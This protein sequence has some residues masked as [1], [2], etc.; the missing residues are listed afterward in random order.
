MLCETNSTVLPLAP[1]VSMRP[2]QRAWNSASPTASTSSTRSISGSKCAATENA[3]RTYIPL[4]YRF[5]G[6]SMKDSTPENS[7]ISGKLRLDLSALHPEDRAVQVDVLAAGELGVESCADLEQASD[8]TTDLDAARRGVRDPGEHLQQRRLAGAVGA[9]HAEHL[10]FDDVER[11]VLQRPDLL[12]L[13]AMLLAREQPSGMDE[14]LSKRSVGSLELPEPVALGEPFDF[15][16][17]GHQIVSAKRGSDDRNT[18]RPPTK[19]SAPTANP[20]AVCPRSG[21]LRIEHCPAPASDHGSHRVERE[22]PLPLRRGSPRP[23]T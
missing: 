4:E 13:T 15:D 8:A 5:T 6:V 7:A 14:R 11:D 16:R 12:H 9:D 1:N 17:N 19:R 21:V 22:D 10:S 23:R 2:R 3:S 20:S 18:A